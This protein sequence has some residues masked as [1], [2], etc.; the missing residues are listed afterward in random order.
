MANKIL[1]TIYGLWKHIIIHFLEIMIILIILTG[2]TARHL[3]TQLVL[4]V[5]KLKIQTCILKISTSIDWYK[6][7]FYNK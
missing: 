1:E 4:R 5:L 6:I 3:E 2:L 7:L